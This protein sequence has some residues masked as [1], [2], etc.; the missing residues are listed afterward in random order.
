MVGSSFEGQIRRSGS[1]EACYY[2]LIDIDHCTL[3]EGKIPQQVIKDERVKL[4]F[5]SPSGEGFK[6]ICELS[7]PCRSLEEYKVF[8]KMFAAEFAESIHLAGS[9]DLKTCD[10]TRA[11]F[12]AFDENT[13]Y[14]P[15]AQTVDWNHYVPSELSDEHLL[16]TQTTVKL[17]AVLDETKYQGVLKAINPKAIV[18]KEPKNITVPTILLEMQSDFEHLAKGNNWQMVDLVK[19]NY[20]IKVIVK[21]GY[22]VAEVNVFYGKKGFSIVHS[23]KTGTDQL[24]AE[25]LFKAISTLLFVPEVTAFDVP[26]NHLLMNN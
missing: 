19:I 8:Y 21:Q 1:F 23:P 16:F 15:N 13:F 9:V 2:V 22:R 6:V 5:V 11:C 4:A 3:E 24:L 12:L 18:K 20:G 25:A 14:N 10:A 26:L 17:P 7:S